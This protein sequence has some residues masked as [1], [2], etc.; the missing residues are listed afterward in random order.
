[1]GKQIFSKGTE[2]L[3]LRRRIDTLMPKLLEAYPDRIVVG[4]SRDH[5]KWAETA[6]DIAKKLEYSST[7]E[8]LEAYGFTVERSLEKGGRPKTADPEAVIEELKRRYPN[9]SP[10]HTLH[11]L[12]KEN[13]DLKG[14]LKTI[15]NQGDRPFGVTLRDHLINV[16]ILKASTEGTPTREKSLE[17]QRENLNEL[18]KELQSRYPDG[19]KRPKRTVELEMENP[20]LDIKSFTYRIRQ[21]YGQT[22]SEFFT[23]AGL[24]A[25]EKPEAK[26][27][28]P[29]ESK[30]REHKR[31][32]K[33]IREI[34]ALLAE[35]RIIRASMGIGDYAFVYETECPNCKKHKLVRANLFAWSQHQISVFEPEDWILR[36]G[37]IQTLLDEH[38]INLTLDSTLENSFAAQRGTCTCHLDQTAMLPFGSTD[39]D[40]VS[41]NDH[42]DMTLAFYAEGTLYEGRTERIEQHSEG[43][44]L[45]YQRQPRNK[46]DKNYI[47]IVDQA[48]K[49]LGSM[50]ASLSASIAPLV[51]KKVVN[52][53]AGQI[54]SI[55]TRAQRGPQAKKAEICCSI[56]LRPVN[57]KDPWGWIIEDRIKFLKKRRDEI[58]ICGDGSV[59]IPTKTQLSNYGITR[60]PGAIKTYY[61]VE[62]YLTGSD[63]G[64][65]RYATDALVVGADV[66][67]EQ[68]GSFAQGN[69]L[70]TL[71]D[72]NGN[73]LGNIP[74]LLSSIMVPLMDSGLLQIK[75]PKYAGKESRPHAHPGLKAMVAKITFLMVIDGPGSKAKELSL[76]NASILASIKGNPSEQL[77]RLILYIKANQLEIKYFLALNSDGILYLV[78][79][80]HAPEEDLIVKDDF[81][82][83]CRED[84]GCFY[85]FKQVPD[86]DP[87]SIMFENEIPVGKLEHFLDACDNEE[88]DDE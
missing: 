68:Q 56:T 41:I 23:E 4:L 81:G 88:I 44:L 72:V 63:S 67:L 50:P 85:L 40:C 61:L 33:G 60:E 10:F 7:A 86:E 82:F 6:R 57:K 46:F 28:V 11:D 52:I 34:Q 18:V 55:K 8:F 51:D 22:V 26:A 78:D 65:C 1:M 35:G 15:S 83:E 30:R 31:I 12:A 20:D 69:R 75:L 45:V 3:D 76:R 62:T 49:S 47:G 59:T 14:K 19:R 54:E 42:G 5:K 48:G 32:P 27:I 36:N 2:P 13:P 21:V 73:R 39:A 24:I 25:P 29:P 79:P 87:I 84:F 53:E 66:V 71:Y 38:G 58:N 70:I 74:N 16:G 80:D 64:D 43:D 17:A 37:E 77:T 9:G